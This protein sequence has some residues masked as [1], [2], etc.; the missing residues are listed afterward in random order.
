MIRAIVLGVHY[1][2]LRRLGYGL[3]KQDATV[4]W[5]G[6]LHG[7]VGLALA[8][9]MEGD[10]RTAGQAQQGMRILL[11]VSVAAMLTLLVNAPTMAPLLRKFGLTS[12]SAVKQQNYKDVRGRVNAYAWAEYT[13]LLQ[14]GTHTPY[15]ERWQAAIP[16]TIHLMSNEQ[17][18]RQSLQVQMQAK[19]QREE[20]Q[21]GG[22]S[23]GAEASEVPNQ[24][25]TDPERLMEARRAFLLLVRNAYTTFVEE[26]VIPGRSSLSLD[27]TASL[28]YANDHIDEPLADW[29]RLAQVI[30]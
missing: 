10:L 3:S 23:G 18:R 12:T 21:L 14:Q 2:A 24:G 19:V 20:S 7:G 8:M 4:C 26:G 27:L 5:W 1:P 6:G 22:P 17:E 16:R 30:R 29:K 11:H 25:A 28:A 15:G 9:S 13:K